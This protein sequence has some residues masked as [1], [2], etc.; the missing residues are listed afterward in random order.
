MRCFCRSH[1][2]VVTAF[3]VLFFFGLPR[4]DARAYDL[5]PY[6]IHP[7]PVWPE[8][9][10]DVLVVADIDGDG[11]K[12][13]VVAT[14][15]ADQASNPANDFSLFIFL[16]QPGGLSSPMRVAYTTA[17]QEGD[18]SRGF[19]RRTGIAAADLNGDG[20]DDIVVGTRNGVAILYGNRQ[21]GFVL[22]RV[23]NSTGAAS[24]D[25]PEIADFDRDGFKDIVS[26]NETSGDGK[27]GLT[28]YHGDSGGTF[29]RQLFTD[30][31]SDGGVELKVAD[32]NR[33]GYPDVAI[34][35]LQGL[36][37]G[38]Q[39]FTNDR[40]GGYLAPLYL[41]APSQVISTRTMSIGDF[42]GA[43]GR[44]DLVMGGFDF[45]RGL[46]VYKQ[47]ELGEF[48]GPT[49]A[50]TSNLD[51]GNYV[52]D[53]SLGRDVDGDQRDDFIVWRS[54]GTIGVMLSDGVGLTPEKNYAGPYFTWGGTRTL[55][56]G[57]LNSDGCQDL[58]AASSNHGLVVWYGRNCAV[59][60]NGT[61]SLAP[62]VDPLVSSSGAMVEVSRSVSVSSRGAS[63]IAMD[64][65]VSAFRFGIFLVFLVLVAA[66]VRRLHVVRRV[67]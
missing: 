13:A 31:R 5:S 49:A 18:N 55:D 26:H 25:A 32:L 12:D 50:P 48:V 37:D 22:R 4:G 43:D 64:R 10:P 1:R 44:V 53:A 35:W 17:A 24:G 27:F 39:V 61:R 51:N 45:S 52:P 16:Q 60:V 46:Y 62:P 19:R 3:A 38:V 23:P 40:S 34:S 36:D 54:G 30:T 6:T 14:T 57:D 11:R 8:T 58:A 56:V 63:R 29:S 21:R 41:R 2:I 7:M 20:C 15:M 66:M 65:R 28:L 59:A 42:A 47:N 67:G 33:D 9:W